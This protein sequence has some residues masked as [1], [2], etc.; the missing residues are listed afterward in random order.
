MS[1][2][3]VIALIGLLGS[4]L[5]AAIAG[6]AAVAAAGI[7]GKGEGSVSCGLVGLLA[8]LG[9]AG[10]LVLG[11]FF[12]AYLMQGRTSQPTIQSNPTA[13]PSQ[14]LPSLAT[15]QPMPTTPPQAIGGYIPK[16]PEEAAALFGGPPASAW[17]QCPGEPLGCWT[18]AL[19]RTSYRLT[20]PE[21][22]LRPDGSID[23]WRYGGGYGGAPDEIQGTTRIWNNIEAATIRCH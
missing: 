12:G 17:K 14:G 23:S 22:C 1:E 13:L 9:A 7:K 8:S 3:I 18:F 19:P 15:Q 2:G 16:S 4:V 5:G 6:F 21:N 11:A 20:V 10:G